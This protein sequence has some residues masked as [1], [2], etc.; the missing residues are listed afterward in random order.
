M[1]SRFWKVGELAKA[2]GTTVRTLH[3]YEEVGLLSPSYRSES[4]HRVYGE[5][6]VIRLQQILSLKQ[7]GFPLEDIRNCLSEKKLTP[8]DVVRMHRQRVEEDS[9]RLLELRNRLT[10]LERALSA[11]SPVSVDEFIK[12]IEVIQMHEKYF[13]KEQ[14]Q[15]LEARKTELGQDKIKEV[16]TRWE[17]LTNQVRSAMEKGTDPTESNVQKLAAEWNSLVTAFTG[18]NPKI[19]FGLQNMYSN[20]PKMREN[21]GLY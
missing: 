1:S 13:S 10:N 5:N 21:V 4:G 2:S 18:G 15:D 7:L 16:Q 11:Q 17:V 20:E 9:E 19:E 6:D 3:H 14:L 12:T 8:L